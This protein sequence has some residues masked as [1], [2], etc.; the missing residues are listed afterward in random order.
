MMAVRRM[1]QAAHQRADA[2]DGNI[3]ALGSE[4]CWQTPAPIVRDRSMG[5]NRRPGTGSGVILT[6]VRQHFS[7]SVLHG[8]RHLGRGA[9]RETR[10]SKPDRHQR[11]MRCRFART[12]AYVMSKDEDGCCRHG[13]IGKPIP[14]FRP[15][16]ESP[17]MFQS[18]HLAL[19][20]LALFLWLP[21]PP[22][23]AG[24]PVFWLGGGG[25]PCNFSSLPVALG[26]VPQGAII[27]IA[28]NQ[29]YTDINLAIT[30]L[31]VTLEGGWADCAG[32][33]S[34][35]RTVLEGAAGTG[36][37]VL[38]VEAAGLARSVRLE[39]LH[40]RGGTRSGIEVD[41]LL[42]VR[43]SDTVVSASS[44]DR[45]GG[46]RVLGVS[47][48]QTVLR[49]VQSVIG[50][51]ES[52]VG[53]GNAATEAGG[54][55]HCT[56]GRVQL[57]GARVQDNLAAYGGGLSL[58]GCLLDLGGSILDVPSFG[59]LTALIAGNEAQLFG[60]G[61][62]A[63]SASELSLD[64]GNARVIVHD[65]L[66]SRGG[67]VYLSGAAT[68]L[69]GVGIQLSANTADS[70]GGGA[71]V[72]EGA[73]MELR[74]GDEGDFCLPRSPCSRVIDNQVLPAPTSAAS[75]IQV[76]GASV[77]LDQTEVRGNHSA[78][79]GQ[80]SV[81]ISGGGSMRILNSLLHDNP[82]EDGSLVVLSGLDNNLAISASTIAGNLITFPL[83]RIDASEGS[84]GLHLDRSVIW[85][86][87]SLV[88]NAAVGDDVTSVCMNAHAGGGINAE[89]HDP[90][91]VDADGGDFRPYASSPNIDACADVTAGDSIDLIGM[92]R[93]IAL[94][95]GA[96][97]FDRGAYELGDVLFADGFEPSP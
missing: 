6:N 47:P 94:G 55:V 68:R 58:D 69:D 35:D 83:I 65:N 75:A 4:Q 24:G 81:H 59:P 38:R 10:P 12:S 56:D 41:G 27:R 3:H 9:V 60:G 66:A 20:A 25:A 45:G 40:I 53:P 37:P 89:N 8:L 70:F 96:T 32:T 71:Y 11:F 74:R 17:V 77:W 54:G 16:M 84:A 2:A 95:A 64:T 67:G 26:A 92:P 39:H 49:L 7:H 91:F 93:P 62:Y 52:G 72:Q 61:V 30:D 82:N 33:P 28:G 14:A 1:R 73:S 43:L 31:S 86:P 87:G 80:A 21:P 97:P 5:G 46:I 50:S 13:R 44:S 19:P 76:H 15:A 22:A 88:H 18:A 48:Q 23:L 51:P 29:P 34:D 85:Q 79:A 36:L 57:S 78:F 42:D 90:G 63:V